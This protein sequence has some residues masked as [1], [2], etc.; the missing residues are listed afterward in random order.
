MLL[1]Y[2]FNKL[3]SSRHKIYTKSFFTNDK[4]IKI[5]RKRNFKKTSFG[6]LKKKVLRGRLKKNSKH[7]ILENNLFF[8]SKLGLCVDIIL[9]RTK[10]THSA[11]IILSNGISFY[12]KSSHGLCIG[13]YFKVLNELPD[14]ES[15]KNFLNLF[16]PFKKGNYIN[17]SNYVSLDWIDK[18]SMVYNLFFKYARSSGTYCKVFRRQFDDEFLACYLPSKK[19]FILNTRFFVLL[20]RCSNTL[21]K[22]EVVGNAGSNYHK[23]FRSKTRGV[24]TNPVDHP[25]GGRTKTCRPLKNIWGKIAKKGK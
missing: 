15:S 1:G 6:I 3:N 24:A 16:S 5:F 14:E 23:G 11:Y 4:K 19:K 13:N 18:K 21:R 25:N 12:L 10:R 17:V 20:G 2:S 22:I 9:D 7:F 8:L